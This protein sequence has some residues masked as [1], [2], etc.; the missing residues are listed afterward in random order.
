MKT[1]F[2]KQAKKA[3]LTSALV[4]RLDDESKAYVCQAAEQRGIS[5]SEYIRQVTVTQAR[6]EV[7]APREQPM[8]L[9]S[10]EQLAFWTALNESPQLTEAQH[11]L[12]STI[13]GES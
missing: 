10:V 8:R 7:I 2:S 13:R 12:G 3:P 11:R 9:T 6:R 4:V 1:P 5:V